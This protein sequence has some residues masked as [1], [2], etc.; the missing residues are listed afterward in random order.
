MT[1]KL[2]VVSAVWLMEILKKSN[3]QRIPYNSHEMMLAW[4]NTI[5]NQVVYRKILSPCSKMVQKCPKHHMILMEADWIHPPG[6]NYI[7]C[8]GNLQDVP[9]QKSCCFSRFTNEFDCRYIYVITPQKAS[10][11]LI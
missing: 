11:P 8:L 3:A 7:K 1:A 10:N 4:R 5:I 6:I 9:P 2:P